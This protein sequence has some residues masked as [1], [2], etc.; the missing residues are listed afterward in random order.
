MC[1]VGSTLLALFSRGTVV[2]TLAA[3]LVLHVQ[4]WELAQQ[5]SKPGWGSWSQWKPLQ[6]F[7]G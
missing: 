7:F 6:A 4:V 1:L 3:A 5:C 2:P